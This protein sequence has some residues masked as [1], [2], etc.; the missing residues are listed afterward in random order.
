MRMDHGGLDQA[1][2]LLHRF[3]RPTLNLASISI[4]SQLQFRKS[5]HRFIAVENSAK[6]TRILEPRPEHAR[7]YAERYEI[8]RDVYP[9]T[10][11][12]T[13]RLAALESGS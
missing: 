3:A 10:R 11:E 5:L 8:Y 13:H 2:F 9:A 7:R 6:I 1:K 12:I 4:R